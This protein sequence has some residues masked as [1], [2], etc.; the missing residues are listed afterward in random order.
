MEAPKSPQRLRRDYTSNRQ[1]TIWDKKWEA[2]KRDSRP[3][4][5]QP[6]S[7][8]I[9]HCRIDGRSLAQ[10]KQEVAVMDCLVTGPKTNYQIQQT[11][12]L[13]KWI[14]RATLKRLGNM[15]TQN[16]RTAKWHLC[17]S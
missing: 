14:V 5:P 4:R 8:E 10:A 17:D 11:T 1:P 2:M 16:P 15:V 9:K 7:K 13:S 6:A 12:G 3:K